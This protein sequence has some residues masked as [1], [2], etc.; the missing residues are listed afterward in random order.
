[1]RTQLNV[2]IE[3][4]LMKKFNWMAEATGMTKAALLSTMIRMA[5]IKTWRVKT[6]E[7]KF[8]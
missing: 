5:K 8:R 7:V 3:P 4:K 2:V 1:M 6:V